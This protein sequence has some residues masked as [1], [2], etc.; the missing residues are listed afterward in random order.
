MTRHD[1]SR[2][3]LSVALRS[4]KQET[5]LIGQVSGTEPG[6]APQECLVLV[7][8]L[9]VKRGAQQHRPPFVARSGK[10]DVMP[11]DNGN[12]PGPLYLPQQTEAKGGFTPIHDR[13]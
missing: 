2:S 5:T 9:F 12:V 11:A 6:F 10:G 3:C 8:T 1:S 7:T 13:P 4:V